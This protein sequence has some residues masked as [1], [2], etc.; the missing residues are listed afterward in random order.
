MKR[1]EIMEHARKMG[2]TKVV[3]KIFDKLKINK[4]TMDD[5]EK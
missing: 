3:S 5:K 4:K 1:E 2:I